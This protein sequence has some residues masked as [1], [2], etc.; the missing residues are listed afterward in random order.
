[1]TIGKQI[2]VSL[3]LDDAG[4]SAKMRSASGD[5]KSL[6]E[7]LAALGT[8]LEKVEG[9]MGGTARDLKSF[10]DG[11]TSANSR[12]TSS[13]S[14]MQRKLIENYTRSSKESRQA[15]KDAAAVAD[16]Q[17]DARERALNNE[18]ASNR[19]IIA[20]RAN[21][22]EN[23][24]KAEREAS[25]RALRARMTLDARQ[26]AMMTAPIGSRMAS[27]AE[28]EKDAAAIRREIALHEHNATAIG[29][30][31]LK[32]S[33]GINALHRMNAE[34][35]QS[36]QALNAERAAVRSNLQA[37]EQ[38]ANLAQAVGRGN[39]TEMAKILAA[40]GTNDQLR[41]IERQRRDAQLQNER[42]M[43]QAARDTAAEQR[44]QARETANE[45]RRQVEQVAAMWKNMAQM[46][47]AGKIGEGLKNSVNQADNYQRTLERVDAAGIDAKTGGK[48]RILNVS[49]NVEAANPNMSRNESLQLTMS[50]VAGAVSTDEKM[51][52]TIVPEIAKLMT[53][54]NR[55]FPEQA[56][57]LENFGRNVMGVMEARGITDNPKKMLETLDNL[58][59]ALILTQG[60]MTV[61]DYETLMRRGGAGSGMLKDNES[62]LYDV[63]AAS[64][65]KV[66]GGGAG[67]GAG[68]VSTFANAQQMASARMQGSTRETIQGLQNQIEFGIVDKAQIMAKNGGKQLG[69]RYK[70]VPYAGSEKAADN[71]TKFAMELV[72]SIKA[73]LAKLPLT[74]MR[75]F[76][77]GDDRN[78]DEAQARAFGRFADQT[79]QNKSAREFYKMFATQGSQHRITAE[80]EA[81]R[82]A[83]T[84]GETHQKA[85][86]SWGVSVDKTKAAL[87]DLGVVVGNELIPVLQPMLVTLTD[88]IRA[89]VKFGQENPM[90]AKLAAIATAAMG[91]ALSFKAM[92]GMAGMVGGI[93]SGIS[94][95]AG[96]NGRLAQTSGAVVGSSRAQRQ[97]HLDNLRETVRV[98]QAQSIYRNEALRVAQANVAGASGMARLTAVTNQLVPAQ[99]AAQGA[100]SAAAVAQAN[101]QRAQAASAIGARALAGTMSFLGGPIGAVITL[102]TVGITAWAMWGNAA[103]A[104]Q[105]KAKQASQDSAKNVDD[106]IKRLEDD[107]VVQKQ[108]ENA[109][110]VQ[111]EQKEIAALKKA[112]A[113][114]KALQKQLQEAGPARNE[115]AEMR[116]ATRISEIDQEIKDEQLA[117]DTR[118]GKLK[119]LGELALSRAQ[120]RAEAEAKEQ[121]EMQ[122]RIAAEIK[123]AQEA[124]KKGL[125]TPGLVPDASEDTDPDATV[126]TE[127]MFAKPGE[128]KARNYVDPLDKALEQMKGKV[129]AA[130]IGLTAL[131]NDAEEVA[132][133][134]AEVE[135]E[136]EGKRKAGDYNKDKDKDNKVAA[137]DPRFRRLVEETTQLRLLG[138]QKKALEFVNQRVAA[139]EVDNAAAVERTIGVT[140]AQSDG[141]LALNR[142]LERL[143]KRLGVGTDKFAAWDKAKSRALGTQAQND[144]LNAAAGISAKVKEDAPDML[145]TE[146]ERQGAKLAAAAKLEDDKI[147]VLQNS[148]A[149]Q[150][151]IEAQALTKAGAKEDEILA[152][153]A[154][155]ANARDTLET[156]YALRRAQ[157]AEMDARALET[158]LQKMVRD[159]KDTGTAIESIQANVANG[160]VNMLSTALTTGKLEFKGFLQSILLEIANAKIKEMLANQFKAMFDQGIGLV[161]QGMGMLFGTPAA[162][163]AGAAGAAAPAAGAAIGTAVADTAGTAAKT[164]AETAATAAITARTAA[165]TAGTAATTARTAGDSAATAAITALTAADSAA[166]AA[167]TANV[168]GMGAMTAAITTA[169]AALGALA[170]AAASAAAAQAGSSIGAAFANGGILT[171]EGP[172]EL[173]KYANGGIA[174]SPQLALYGEAGP[175]AY[176]PLPDGR[177][178]P[179]TM[180]T[181][182]A[183]ATSAPTGQVMLPSVSVNVINQTGTQASA[184]QGDVRFDGKGYVLDVVMTAASQPGPFRNTMKEA[185]K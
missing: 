137:N 171:S 20:S 89:M 178:I 34:R 98:T 41:A 37:K 183:Q 54:M 96:A 136:L 15:A 57:N 119:R 177:T 74:D 43:R 157:R 9:T 32:T 90:V 87:R 64:Q 33:E 111:T 99:R 134:R 106:T 30:E 149:R 124:A 92:T 141:L 1:M 55:Q 140:A 18:I 145:P 63:A 158:P 42:D 82:A 142:E 135:A 161:T 28:Y 103:Q 116:R 115:G 17:I 73:K 175:E 67:G 31:V 13:I 76:A 3:S 130:K 48:Q 131:K 50:A 5:V 95:L 170:S 45:Q 12:L 181:E 113:E 25:D 121:K 143:E 60:K 126:D 147:Q 128:K 6:R 53:V 36:I 61:Q 86:D 84:Y 59:R 139:T 107:I 72:N 166:L 169:V 102:L 185:L 144:A 125:P 118:E 151:A 68:G 40:R 152:M 168:A 154:R 38:A 162:G 164:G 81:S 153:R 101:L 4:F 27:S 163:G 35:Q 159:W 120:T 51:L 62:I 122:E 80:V 146:R 155:Y 148:L 56:H 23:L 129:A 46:Y 173:R 123:A 22:H 127:G 182:G 16:A 24:R 165:E 58:A 174:N 83:P 105:K 65:M 172:V 93:T 2:K 184:K 8:G 167:S 26:K 11:V 110:I 132:T 85:M 21:L 180:K 69:A 77:K 112:L 179:V 49:K 150:E 94:A 176:V 19:K 70:M 160:F 71:P 91:A 97:A 7:V 117:I 52:N 29:L 14:Q 79:W 133:L 66:M 10:S 156:T 39:A 114:K 44:R 104:A 78:S 138:E 108:G 75:F 47:A 88:M 100:A 109:P